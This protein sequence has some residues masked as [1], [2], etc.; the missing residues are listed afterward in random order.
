MKFDRSKCLKD[1][2]LG[3]FI[4]VII[5]GGAYGI[6]LF[7]TRNNLL[8][9]WGFASQ[10]KHEIAPGLYLYRTSGRDV[11]LGDADGV[12]LIEG[13]IV[14]YAV[15]GTRLYIVV[16]KDGEAE[17]PYMVEKSNGEHFRFMSVNKDNGV[18]WKDPF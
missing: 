16:K 8:D 4:M 13:N 7:K 18:E 17:K 11:M 3:A 6:L 2:I 15:E 14:M 10:T 9:T 12:G 1:I 5:V